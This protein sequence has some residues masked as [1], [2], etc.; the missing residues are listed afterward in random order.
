MRERD[1][2]SRVQLFDIPLQPRFRQTLRIYALPQGTTCC[3]DVT[4]RFF[5]LGGQLLHSTTV[6]L[7]R[8]DKAVGDID[9]GWP[10]SPDFPMQ[11][12]NATLDFLGNIAELA[13][14]ESVRVEVDGGS[15]AIWGM[16]T[17][18]NNDTQQVTVI[19]PQ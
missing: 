15:R 2:A 19:S 12:E 17:V 9:H 11:P 14:R 7:R 10:G 4:V 16:V 8:S 6:A 13:G 18:T 5:A 1:F 3:T